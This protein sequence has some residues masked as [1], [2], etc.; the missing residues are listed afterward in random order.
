MI[1][2]E[3]T[4]CFALVPYNGTESLLVVRKGVIITEDVFR[5]YVLVGKRGSSSHATPTNAL[6]GRAG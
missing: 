3:C 2:M 4:V 5:L 6:G 1:D